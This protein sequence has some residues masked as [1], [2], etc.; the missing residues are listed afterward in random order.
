MIDVLDDDW[1]ERARLD[2]K[3][4]TRK[5]EGDPDTQLKQE[6]NSGSM[7]RS[8]L[9]ECLLLE[10][11]AGHGRSSPLARIIRSIFADASPRNLSDFPEVFSGETKD[12]KHTGQKRKRGNKFGDYND[13]D[14]EAGGA[15]EII[16]QPSDA[17]DMQE[18]DSV[19]DFDPY[20]GGAEVM[21]LRQKLV[22]LLSRAAHYRSAD[23]VDT[24]DLYEAVYIGMKELPVPAFSLFT[25]PPFANKLPLEAYVS[26]AMLY[27]LR[28]L[29]NN[30]PPP[31]KVQSK[32]ADE[33]SDIVL[34]K[35]YL[36]FAASTSSVAD[37]ARVSI[38][39]ENLLRMFLKA[40]DWEHSARFV[41]AIEKG[42]VARENKVKPRRSKESGGKQIAEQDDLL[43]L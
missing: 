23:F 5:K 4:E 42:I 24:Y 6:M 11:L 3:F 31:Y 43:W 15:T 37:N 12:V 36:P 18:E 16:D 13:E 10:Y 28:L 26:V 9:Q 33:I 14:E 30:A 20:L 34:E 29:P 27:L 7:P 8:R 39:V 32:A 38:Q 22:K 25:A 41:A 2:E 21:A 35:C 17:T 1:V 19:G 40:C